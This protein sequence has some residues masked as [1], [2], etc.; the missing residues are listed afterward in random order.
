M[1]TE[2]APLKLLES[3]VQFWYN[4]SKPK[5]I[6]HHRGR[7]FSSILRTRSTCGQYTLPGY[8]STVRNQTVPIAKYYDIHICIKVLTARYLYLA[9]SIS[10]NL[11]SS[12]SLSAQASISFPYIVRDDS[13]IM[14]VARTGDVASMET[15]FRAR[16]ASPSDRLSSGATLLHASDTV[17][18]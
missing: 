9:Y 12:A 13:S 10:R 7:G 1:A 14:S 2:R 17:S 5:A 16:R 6:Y 11:G 15:M 4:C 18:Q 8:N 3:S